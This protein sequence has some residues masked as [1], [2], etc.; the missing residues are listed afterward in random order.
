MNF[1][2]LYSGATSLEPVI[3]NLITVLSDTDYQRGA[4]YWAANGVTEDAPVQPDEPIILAPFALVDE[5]VVWREQEGKVPALLIFDARTDPIEEDDNQVELDTTHTI[6]LYLALANKDRLLLRRE[7]FWRTLAVD[8]MIRSCP[9]SVLFSNTNIKRPI[10]EVLRRRYDGTAGGK[11]SYT[12][13]PSID[14]RIR[15]KER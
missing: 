3:D 8:M 6:S 5:A 12:R 7:A 4:H 13:V 2:P 11:S 14:V 15:C 9:H 10:V 1:T